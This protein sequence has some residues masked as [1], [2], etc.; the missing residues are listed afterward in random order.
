MTEREIDSEG[1]YSARKSYAEITEWFLGKYGD[2]AE[3]RAI[4]NKWRVLGTRAAEGKL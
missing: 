2:N 1:G 3:N 4:D